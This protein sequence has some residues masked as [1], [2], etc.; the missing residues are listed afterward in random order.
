MAT[1]TA[2]SKSASDTSM[3]APK[4]SKP[5]PK[6]SPSSQAATT[7]TTNIGAENDPRIFSSL[8]ESSIVD[9]YI[10]PKRKVYHVHRALVCSASSHFKS[11]FGT[12]DTKEAIKDMYLENHD[13]EVFEL[14]VTYLYRGSFAEL[15]PPTQQGNPTSFDSTSTGDP[16]SPNIDRL[17]KLYFM[18]TD[19]GVLGLRNICLDHLR[20]Y[21]S[22]SG[23]CFLDAELTT[24][25]EKLRSPVSRLRKFA[26]DQG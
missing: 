9:F 20:R 25:S 4:S 3:N 7:P 18:A 23:R 24:I 6:S 8:L 17:L 16:H 12:L 13:P 26:V 19:Y 10:G 11:Y 22:K 5:D 15:I 2:Q 14:F 21:M 1:S